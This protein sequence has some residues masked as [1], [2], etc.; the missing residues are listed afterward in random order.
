MVLL[1][2]LLKFGLKMDKSCINLMDSGTRTKS[3]M[4]SSN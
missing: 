3:K 1:I 4:N 2:K